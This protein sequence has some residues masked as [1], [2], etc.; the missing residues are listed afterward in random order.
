MAKVSAT[1]IQA[2]LAGA[3]ISGQVAVGEH[4]VQIHAEHGAIVNY[5]RRRDARSRGLGRRPSGICRARSMRCSVATRCWRSCTARLLSAEPAEVVGEPGIGKTSLLRNV[6][7][8]LAELQPD[9]VVYSAVAGDAGIRP[10]PVPVR[11]LL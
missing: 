2:D 5:N 6:S 7:H 1:M 11:E 4:I 8:H 3:V 9:G 10:A